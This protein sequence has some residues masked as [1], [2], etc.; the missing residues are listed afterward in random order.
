MKE[1][2]KSYMVGCNLSFVFTI[3]IAEKE[4]SVCFLYI[5]DG[6]VETLIKNFWIFFSR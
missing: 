6:E 1:N 5:F 4:D 2:V 3:S